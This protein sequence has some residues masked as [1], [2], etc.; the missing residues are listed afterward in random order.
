VITF[1]AA[2]DFLLQ[3]GEDY[4]RAFEDA[5]ERLLPSGH[6]QR[7]PGQCIELAGN[8]SELPQKMLGK[9]IVSFLFIQQRITV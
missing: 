9:R 7:V 8:I 5:A 3:H 6:E 2:R 4:E 1:E